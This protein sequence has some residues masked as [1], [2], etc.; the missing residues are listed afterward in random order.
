MSP[1]HSPL[2]FHRSFLKNSIPVGKS[3]EA[4]ERA[5]LFAPIVYLRVDESDA[6]RL[7][8][9]GLDPSWCVFALSPTPS[10]P[11]TLLLPTIG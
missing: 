6:P 2:T 11:P 4:T 7:S 9:G 10:F 5:I 3:Q 1:L 8:L